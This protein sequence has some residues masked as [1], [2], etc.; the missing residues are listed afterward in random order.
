MDQAAAR[1]LVL[2][3]DDDARAARLL[4]IMLREDGFRVEVAVDGA[5]AVRR[6]SREPVPHV[7]V[8]D[9]YLSHADGVTV[10]RY[11][12]SRRAAMGLFLITGYPELAQEQM[13]SFNPPPFILTKPVVYEHLRSQIGALE[14]PT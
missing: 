7:L 13:A 2:V 3:V 4:A 6:L 14:A 12:R 1:L 8:T 9:L 10:A 5:A 11:A